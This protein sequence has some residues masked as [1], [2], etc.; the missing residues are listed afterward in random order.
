MHTFIKLRN[1]RGETAASFEILNGKLLEESMKG[2]YLN[3]IE[4]TASGHIDYEIDMSVP[5]NEL[6]QY[7]SRRLAEELVDRTVE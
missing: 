3:D 5:E 7:S 6:K 2:C 4:E 1:D